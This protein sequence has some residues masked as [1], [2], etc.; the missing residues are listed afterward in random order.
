MEACSSIPKSPVGSSPPNRNASPSSSGSRAR[1]LQPPGGTAVAAPEPRRPDMFS[2]HCARHG[3]VV[4]LAVSDLLTIGAA[5]DG[6]FVIGYRCTCGFEGQW[7][8][9]PCEE[10]RN[11]RMAG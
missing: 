4:L 3:R 10:Q 8:P 11:E 9:A 1:D 7:P 5:A 6:G 2:V